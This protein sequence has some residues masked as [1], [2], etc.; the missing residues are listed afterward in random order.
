MDL[1][2]HEW[3][4]VRQTAQQTADAYGKP[5]HVYRAMRDGKPAHF[6]VIVAGQ[7]RPAGVFVETVQPTPKGEQA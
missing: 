1:F 3:R 5:V 2:N 6:S 7:D 4:D